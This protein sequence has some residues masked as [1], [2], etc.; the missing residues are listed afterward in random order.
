MFSHFLNFIEELKV[1]LGHYRVLFP[2]PGVT[3]VIE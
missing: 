2:S 3:V 1:P